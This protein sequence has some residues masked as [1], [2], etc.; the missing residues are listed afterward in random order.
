LGRARRV[1]TNTK[2][3]GALQDADNERMEKEDIFGP[4]RE[5]RPKRI[6]RKE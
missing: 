5:T 6:L 4:G 3:T 2:S 1:N